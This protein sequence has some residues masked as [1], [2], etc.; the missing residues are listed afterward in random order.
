MAYQD[1]LD[2]K[3]CF[4]KPMFG[5]VAVKGHKPII[6]VVAIHLP[7][8]TTATSTT[9]EGRIV[10]QHYALTELVELVRGKPTYAQLEA[11][12]DTLQHRL[13]DVQNANQLAGKILA[14]HC[15]KA[16]VAGC[17]L[18]IDL[19]SEGQAVGAYPHYADEYAE[20]I[21]RGEV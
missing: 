17:E 3:D 15:R 21:R 20:K 10:D 18:V 19:S 11:E 5:P 2:A 4:I 8:T 13:K 16:F 12:R 6:G 7:T 1:E 9:G 14:D